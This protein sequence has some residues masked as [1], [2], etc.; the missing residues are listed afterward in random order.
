MVNELKL[1]T[2]SESRMR[3]NSVFCLLICVALPDVVMRF[4]GQSRPQAV[5]VHDERISRLGEVNVVALMVN[6]R[7]SNSNDNDTLT[8][9]VL[10][11]M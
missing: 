7:L 10:Y 4:L 5:T 3:V 6:A 8:N 11:I 2:L 9:G 1:L